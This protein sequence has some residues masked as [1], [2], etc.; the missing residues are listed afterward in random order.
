MSLKSKLKME[1]LG[2]AVFSIF[3]AIVG[4]VIFSIVVVSGFTI[5]HAMVLAFLS[6]VTAYSL[7]KMK[8]WS[9][10]LT[11]TLFFLG[12]AFSA[13]LLYRSITINS[14][15]TTAETVLL[16]AALILHIIML[17]AALIYVVTKRE[18]FQ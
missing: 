16:D 17:F 15:P 13:P 1:S 6:L 14:L 3:Y 2:I 5:P 10:L 9:V 18:S 11:I 7:F 8:E 12:T 4:I